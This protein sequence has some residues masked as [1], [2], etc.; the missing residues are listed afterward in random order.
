MYSY[1]KAIP[2]AAYVV[3]GMD[4]VTKFQALPRKAQA[5]I[6]PAESLRL[7]LRVAKQSTN[8]EQDVACLARS[9][10]RARF[11]CRD[12]TG[13]TTQVWKFPVSVIHRL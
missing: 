2:P 7:R 3:N 10:K 12:P 8:V 9:I 1:S 13:I 6:I 4:I 11:N 5:R